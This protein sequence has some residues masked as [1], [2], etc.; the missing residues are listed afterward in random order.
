MIWSTVRVIVAIAKPL[1]RSRFGLPY[2]RIG[3]VYPFSIIGIASFPNKDAVIAK[4]CG[5]VRS[6]R[7]EQRRS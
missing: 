1:I 7:S 4:A 6:Q 2:L 5:S 3:L